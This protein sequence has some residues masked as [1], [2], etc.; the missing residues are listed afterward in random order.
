MR[1]EFINNHQQGGELTEEIF[2]YLLVAANS[3]AIT[4]GDI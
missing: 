1:V 3:S 4:S 2:V